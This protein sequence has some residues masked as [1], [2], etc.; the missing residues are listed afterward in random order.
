VEKIDNLLK[1]E[2]IT[3]I[4]R[5]SV[6]KELEDL[7]SLSKEEIRR[8][9]GEKEK[10]YAEKMEELKRKF[11]AQEEQLKKYY[12]SKKEM[13]LF[14]ERSKLRSVMYERIENEIRNYIFGLKGENR[15][16]LIRSLFEE[17][18]KN[19]E[20]DFRVI[21]KEEDAGIIK[22]FFDGEIEVSDTGGDLILESGRMRIVV[23]VES[24]LESLKDD[25]ASFIDEKVGELS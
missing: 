13:M 17:A 16:K 3:N 8:F 15:K 21:C 5:K 10:E 9:R 12:E 14:Q 7:R 2:R 24:I 6:E 11:D 18:R 22:E 23:G 19:I 25:I 1:L 20:G 4:I